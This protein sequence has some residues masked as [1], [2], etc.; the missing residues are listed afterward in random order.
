MIE[1][2]FEGPTLAILSGWVAAAFVIGEALFR[3]IFI[4]VILSRKGFSPDSRIAWIVVILAIPLIGWLLYLM[5]GR[6]QLG[7]QRIE[8]HKEVLQIVKDARCHPEL[9]PDVVSDI[10][11][12]ESHTQIASLAEQASGTLPLRGNKLK[13]F[14]DTQ[15]T[16]A[17]IINDIDAA[18][19]DCHLLFYIWLEDGN[20]IAV[21]KALIRAAQRGVNARVLVDDVGSRS[22]LKSDLCRTMRAQGV[23]VVAALPANPLRAIFHRI[24]LRN[25]RKIIIIDGEIGWTDSQ[26]M[27]DA[28]FAPKPKLIVILGSHLNK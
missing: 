21:G 26:N 22:F 5:F 7:S 12:P 17:A 3:F 1:A 23:Q 9:D 13:L 27:A 20:G 8:R 25:H 10:E 4:T 28:A 19:H 11:L 2:L 24:D 18:Q 14:G 6:R 16:V 15:D